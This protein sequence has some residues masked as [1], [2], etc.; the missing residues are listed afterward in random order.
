[1]SKSQRSLSVSFSRTD[2][3]LCIYHFFV[4]SNLNF[5]HISLFITLPTHLYLVLYSFC[6]NLLHSL[7]IWLM[8]SSLSPHYYYFT[9]LRV[10]HTSVRRWFLNGLLSDSKSPQVSRTL[11]SILD[12][13]VLW[14]VSIR[15]LISKSSSPC[16]NLL[17]TVQSAPITI[18]IIV[19]FMFHIFSHKRLSHTVGWQLSYDI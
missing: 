16:T 5:L 15:P 8:A 17:V 6:A 2:A 18:D 12:N 11:L 1:M 10:F 4:W 7:I 9:L 13:V 14:V 19:T 3:G